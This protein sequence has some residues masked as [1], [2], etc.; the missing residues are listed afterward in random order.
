MSVIL[1]AL[2]KA[3]TTDGKRTSAESRVVDVRPANGVKIRPASPL[4]MVWLC[5]SFFVL[6]LVGAAGA[7]AFYW[8]LEHRNQFTFGF[9]PAAVTPAVAVV[10]SPAPAASDANP[11]PAQPVNNPES[12]KTA[13]LPPPVPIQA[14]AQPTAVSTQALPPPPV[15]APAATQAGAAGNPAPTAA[16]PFALGTILCAD[17]NDCAAIVNGKTV[18]RGD[19]IREHRVI[20]ITSTEVRLQHNAEPP[21]VLSLFR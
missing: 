11:N 13:D 15:A 8:V 19:M 18:H 17:G 7:G 1:E 14:V 6:V 2:Q 12:A 21:I 9:A 4:R 20:E 5:I 10:P 16:A 3:H